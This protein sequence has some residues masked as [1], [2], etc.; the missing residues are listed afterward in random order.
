[1]SPRFAKYVKLKLHIPMQNNDI[2]TNRGSLFLFN[3][4]LKIR[5]KVVNPAVKV[6]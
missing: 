1:M 2:K 5:Q 3:L 4:S 6:P